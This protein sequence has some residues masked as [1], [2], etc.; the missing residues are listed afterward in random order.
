MC[1]YRVLVGRAE[2]ERLIGG[3][4]KNMRGILKW[5]SEECVTGLDSM[6]LI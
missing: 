1:V 6:F 4:G 3:S 5:I 2:G